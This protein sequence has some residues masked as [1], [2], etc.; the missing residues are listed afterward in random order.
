MQIFDHVQ[1]S[2]PRDGNALEF[3]VHE[4]GLSPNWVKSYLAHSTYHPLNILYI[5]TRSFIHKMHAFDLFLSQ[6]S[7]DFPCIVISETGFTNNEYFKQFFKGIYFFVV[8]KL[9]AAE[10]ECALT[11]QRPKRLVGWTCGCQELHLC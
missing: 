3:G 6:L 10:V 7:I 2:K 1:M 11:F 9:Q 5:D 4:H 8:L